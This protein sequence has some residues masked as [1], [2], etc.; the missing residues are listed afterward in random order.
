MYHN[1]V[2]N[3]TIMVMCNRNCTKSGTIHT[4]FRYQT[5]DSTY[6]KR[7]MY[8]YVLMYIIMY[9]TPVYITLSNNVTEEARRR[10]A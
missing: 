2:C 1:M 7:N 5:T 8:K 6:G 10:P 3:T 4:I 9:Q